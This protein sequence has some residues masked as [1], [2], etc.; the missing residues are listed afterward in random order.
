[1]ISKI[2]MELRL[3]PRLSIHR[4]AIAWGRICDHKNCAL[5]KWNLI[6]W[7]PG[8]PSCPSLALRR[9]YLTLVDTYKCNSKKT[10]SKPGDS[11]CSGKNKKEK[12]MQEMQL[13]RRT[14]R[15]E[16]KETKS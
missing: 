7:G 12:E 9:H 2:L 1:M 6:D 14:M 8:W 11:W 15:P 13:H 5:V 3:C 10:R 16:G 4:S